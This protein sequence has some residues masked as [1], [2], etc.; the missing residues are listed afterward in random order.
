MKEV[1]SL[2]KIIE[3]QNNVKQNQLSEIQPQLHYRKQ[4]VEIEKWLSNE[5]QSTRTECVELVGL[6]TEFHGD[7][8]EDHVVDVF[9]TAGVEVKKQR[10]HAIHRLENKRAVIAKLVNQQDVLSILRGKKKLQNLDKGRK[11]R[12]KT[13]KIY[14][15]E[16][17]CPPYR[18]LLGKY[19]VLL[20]RKYI[21][22]FYSVNG[23]LKIKRGPTDD[24][25]TE[26]KHEDDLWQI[27][28]NEIIDEINRRYE[29]SMEESQSAEQS[30]EQ[31]A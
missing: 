5:E 23:K 14:V 27:F 17:L 24:R 3:E 11:K 12:L 29:A 2:K 22:N 10:F 1:D 26:I 4:I 13:Q 15:N 6:P 21:S 30:H 18:N 9:R 20:K 7:Q 28:G 19:N 25:A 31:W 16:S 8:L